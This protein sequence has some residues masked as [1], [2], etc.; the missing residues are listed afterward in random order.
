MGRSSLSQCTMTLPPSGLSRVDFVRAVD[1][2]IR[3]R[4]TRKVLDGPGF[5]VGPGSPA[6]AESGADEAAN[7]E[8]ALRDAIEV[9]G[10]APFHFAREEH[11]PEPWRFHVFVGSGLQALHEKLVAADVLYGKLPAIFEGAG[12]V[13]QATWLPEGE[14]TRDWEHAA[15][16]SAA[17]QN[18]LLATHARGIGSYWCSAPVLGQ[19]PAMQLFGTEATEQYLGT[20]FFGRPLSA[21]EEAERGFAGKMHARRTPPEQGWCRWNGA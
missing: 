21:D 19:A 13:L 3:D 11:L 1:R 9:A 7:F 10:F 18:L 12:A 8:Q 17:V 20:L 4:R 5:E 16:A 2:A 14:P 15:A 6:F